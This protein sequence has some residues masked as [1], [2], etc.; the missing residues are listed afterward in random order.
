MNKQDLQSQKA[1]LDVRN[2]SK[3]FITRH[4]I[5]RAV[6][7]VSFRVAPGEI[8]GLIGQSGSGKS[9]IGNAIMR[10]LS[11]VNGTITLNGKVVSGK[12]SKSQRKEFNRNVQMIFQDPHT[13]LNE[14]RNVFSTIAEPLKVNKIINEKLE[15]FFKN[16]NRTLETFELTFKKTYKEYEVKFMELRKE[17]RIK[18]LTKTVE[19]LKKFS[20]AEFGPDKK[21]QA[22]S[23]LVFA[24]FDHIALA[25]D[26]ILSNL[27]EASNYFSSI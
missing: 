23:E 9:T 21:E 26:K 13:A 1:L 15:D 19:E 27:V 10:L 5:V 11:E 12:I 17:E 4:G 25:E 2:L 20:Y 22:F 16:Y 18:A 3:Y 7:N 8:M 6:D 14:K 24:Y